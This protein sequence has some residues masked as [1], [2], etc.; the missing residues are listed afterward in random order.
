MT[1]G[2]P[3]R[4]KPDRLRQLGAAGGIA[5]V[6]LQAVAQMSLQMG[7]TEPAFNAPTE[8]IV[9]FFAA[10]SS[11]VGEIS[12]FLSGLSLFAFVWFLGA[13]WATLREAEGEPGWLSLTAVTSGI[14][15]V[16]VVFAPG[17]WHLA[18]FR[19]GDGLDPQIARLLFDSGNLGFANMWLFLASMLLAYTAVTLQTSVLPRWT[20]WAAIAIAVSL[21]LARAFWAASGVVFVAYILFQLWLLAVS[22]IL[23]RQTARQPKQTHVAAIP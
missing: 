16:A 2:T 15:A 6:V 11:Q 22:I 5:F 23:L 18:L 13:L 7:G 4:N 19:M 20:G 12:G 9:A 21:L 14:L 17:G 10:K 3:S 8:P 1:G